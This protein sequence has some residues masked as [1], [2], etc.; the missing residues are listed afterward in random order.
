MRVHIDDSGSVSARKKAEIAHQ[1]V[2][3]ATSHHSSVNGEEGRFAI[4]F[5]WQSSWSS[6]LI[7]DPDPHW[8]ILFSIL[9]TLKIA[10]II[11]APP[12]TLNA[13][14]KW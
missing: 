13:G 8:N 9:L 14:S 3:V 5:S 2:L 4:L 12:L 10:K 11:L 7:L 6:I 1:K